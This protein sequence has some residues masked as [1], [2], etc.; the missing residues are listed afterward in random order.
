MNCRG[1]ADSLAGI[2]T[3]CSEPDDLHVATDADSTGQPHRVGNCLPSGAHR[4]RVLT[5]RSRPI[6]Y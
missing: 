1:E 6:F 2:A 4:A 3:R 5:L